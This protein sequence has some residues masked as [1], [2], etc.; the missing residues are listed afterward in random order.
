MTA[1]P[2][3]CGRRTRPMTATSSSRSR[4]G[5]G[6]ASGTPNLVAIGAAAAACVSRAIARGIYEATPA[7]G[8]RMPTWRER[9]GQA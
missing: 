3:R 9:F 6:P 2:G 5:G 8:D 4:P 7:G 1:S